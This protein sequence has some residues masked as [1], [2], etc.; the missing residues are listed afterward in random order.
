MSETADGNVGRH[1]YYNLEFNATYT[2]ATLDK[3][4]QKNWSNE[5]VASCDPVGEAVKAL[6]PTS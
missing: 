2:C 3:N 6:I 4:L 1:V 5:M